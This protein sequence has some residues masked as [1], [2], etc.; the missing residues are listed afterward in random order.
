MV[1]WKM[2]IPVYASYGEIGWNLQPRYGW[3]GLLKEAMTGPNERLGHTIY[4]CASVQ[5]TTVYCIKSKLS[6]KGYVMGL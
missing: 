5:F 3:M 4:L 2:E 1:K 6:Q